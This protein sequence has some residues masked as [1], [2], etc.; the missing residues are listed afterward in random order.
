MSAT[1]PSKLPWPQDRVGMTSQLKREGCRA[2]GRMGGDPTNFDT[3]MSVLRVLARHAQAKLEEQR[4]SR[5]SSVLNLAVKRADQEAANDQATMRTE[6]SL[7][8][9]RDAL[10]LRIAALASRKADAEEQWAEVLRKREAGEEDTL[11][12]DNQAMQ[13]I[14]EAI[15]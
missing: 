15:R 6:N 7:N 8:R 10:D 11:Q 13:G 12:L 1:N 2:I 4:T 14:G 5:A 9:Q 3:V